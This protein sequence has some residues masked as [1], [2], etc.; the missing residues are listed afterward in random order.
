MIAS[1]MHSFST[2]TAIISYMDML[3]HDHAH[4]SKM[5]LAGELL[6]ISNHGGAKVDTD[7]FTLA[8]LEVL[9]KG[10]KD[11]QAIIIGDTRKVVDSSGSSSEPNR[12]TFTAYDTG[13]T[14]AENPPAELERMPR[15]LKETQRDLLDKSEQLEAVVSQRDNLQGIKMQLPFTSAAPSKGKGMAGDE[16]IQDILST[17][18]TGHDDRVDVGLLPLDANE[19]EDKQTSNDLAEPTPRRVTD[20]VEKELKDIQ[21]K[22]L[23][24]EVERLRSSLD[25]IT[26]E[27][28]AKSDEL[29]TALDNNQSL[30]EMIRE[31][32]DIDEETIRFIVKHISSFDDQRI[33][34]C[35]DEVSLE[36]SYSNDIEDKVERRANEDLSSF[37]SAMFITGKFLVDREL[38]EDSIACF[39]AVLDVRRELYGW[40]D[41]LVGDALHMEGFA[42]TKSKTLFPVLLIAMW[43]NNNLV[44]FNACFHFVLVGDYDRALMLLWDALRIRKITS[45]PLKISATLRLL[46]DLHFSKEENMHAALFYEECARHL[47]EHDMLDPHLPL[48]L[49]DLARTKDRLGE[50]DESMNFFEE[51]L[52]LYGRSLDHD[53]DRIASLQYEMGVLAFQM[54]ERVRGE[55]CFRHFIRIRKSKGSRMDEGVANALFVLGSLHWATKKRDHAQDCWQ[56]ALEIFKGLG[57]TDDDPYVKSLKEKLHR[58]QRRP[59]T[60]IFRGS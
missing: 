54:G 29:E 44:L 7:R 56:E 36:S 42:R 35:D 2:L 30:R 20:H 45:E 55:E 47:K 22:E 46:A 25:N 17:L 24:S 48:V 3:C 14:S 59:I 49:I 15:T 51:A 18:S 28:Y 27:L 26:Q 37:G 52:S 39:E 9:V 21:I 19:E 38:Y 43:R 53:D 13:I 40:D 57:R 16:S 31:T 10:G 23:S 11:A 5:A 6:R 12:S 34:E 4:G 50:Y 60:R 33:E 58:A 41:P 32:P 1:Y 8:M